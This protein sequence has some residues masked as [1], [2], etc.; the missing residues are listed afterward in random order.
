MTRL[1]PTFLQLCVKTATF[2]L[3]W[4]IF[5]PTAT[6]HTLTVGLLLAMLNPRTIVRMRDPSLISFFALPVPILL[7]MTFHR[8]WLVVGNGNPNYIYFQCF[9]Y[10]MFIIIISMDFVSAT[11]KRDKVRRMVEKGSIKKLLKKKEEAEKESQ[12]ETKETNVNGVKQEEIVEESN[13]CAEDKA[14]G[15]DASSQPEP[16]VVFL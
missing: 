7:F 15:D 9:A 1:R 4:A 8:M 12:K 14:A 3:L 13:G 10:G 6:V 16:S 11:V 5:R 2:Q